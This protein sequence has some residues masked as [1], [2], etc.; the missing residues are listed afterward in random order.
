MAAGQPC[1][2]PKGPRGVNVRSIKNLIGTQPGSSWTHTN[3]WGRMYLTLFPKKFFP[4]LSV[5]VFGCVVWFVKIPWR[6]NGQP[7]AVFLPG[8]F[9]GQR[10]LAWR[11]PWTEDSC[12]EDSMGRSRR[13]TVHGVAEPDT[14]EGTQ[15]AA[16]GEPWGA[17]FPDRGA[18]PSVHPPGSGAGAL[19]R[20]P[21]ETHPETRSRGT[22]PR[23]GWGRVWAPPA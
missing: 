6:R 1:C 10:I 23:P 5:V 8:E 19:G 12:L 18:P 13:A 3:A 7:T 11:I 15:Q 17:Q 9:H 22:P 16:G 20:P 14:T 4:Y 21:G 2:D